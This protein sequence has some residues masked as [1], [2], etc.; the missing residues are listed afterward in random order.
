M[1]GFL[2]SEY[3]VKL[4]DRIET[5][6]PQSGMP[7]IPE[8]ALVM[9]GVG[10][11]R[12]A[13]NNAGCA[14][15]PDEIRRYLYQLA[16]PNADTHIVDLGN[17]IIGQTAEDTYYAVAEIVAAVLP[18]GN[19]LILLGGSQDLTYAAYKGYER[20]NRIMNITSID[21]RFDLENNDEIN[22]RTWLQN[23]IMQ[24]PNYLFFN[25]NLGYQTYF[26]GQD[27][28]Q[29]M[30]DLKFDAYRLG[31]LQKDMTRA[32]S[33]I[34]N[35][36]LLSVDIGA[37][38]QSDAPGNRYPSPHG[39][40]G[41]EFCLMMRYAGMSDKTDCLGLFEVNPKFDN[42]GQTAHMT[43]QG[44]WYFIEGF[45]NRKHDNPL[46]NPENCKRF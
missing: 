46:L 9:V 37:I 43:A 8:N 5:H 36:D 19:T 24:N 41:E 33:L 26:V 17:V 2:P 18:K 25:S 39:F 44:L 35:A 20:L 27:Y 38:R 4:G 10:E 31:E 16:V 42:H 28:I 22:S 14:D 11:D 34:R 15:A 7:E 40:Y 13:E 6:T 12:G 45:Y 30:D 21:S 23:I 29:L 3:V 1:L 32:E